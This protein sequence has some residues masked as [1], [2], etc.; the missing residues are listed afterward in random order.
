MGYDW[1]RL[2]AMLNDLPA[3]LLVTAVVFEA[4][5]LAT[6]RSGFRIAGFWTLIAGA[7]GAG[8]AVISGLQA[9]GRIQHSE[10]VHE[11]MQTHE[12]LALVTLSIFGVLAIWRAVR[13]AK[14][15]HGERLVAFSLALCGTATLVATGMYGG[16]MVFEHGAG[17]PTAVMETEIHERAEGHH[18]GAGEAADDHDHADGH[19][20]DAADSTH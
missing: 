6:R 1:P 8:V 16:R 18:H 20:H 3:A 7:L 4:L 5:A 19:D 12:K 2:H 11:L 9:E 14:M 10:A 17:V 13:E 15:A